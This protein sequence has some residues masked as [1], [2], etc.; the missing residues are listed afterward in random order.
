M[1]TYGEL[2]DAVA[3]W[4]HRGDLAP[5]LS[6]FVRFAE[7]KAQRR[8]RVRQMEVTLSPTPIVAGLVARPAD[9][10]AVKALWRTDQPNNPL[11]PRS[12]DFVVSRTP[13]DLAR[14]YAWDGANWRFDGTGSVT[15]VYYRSIPALTGAANWLLTLD[16]QLYLYGTLAEVYGWA[17]DTENQAKYE[18]LFVRAIDELNRA[19]TLDRYSGPLTIG[20]IDADTHRR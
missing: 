19:D 3:S 14:Y 4:S 7:I 12:L 6:Q 10:V 15:G 9:A 2:T 8:L 17:E 18:G 16:P 11:E 20:G 1:N 13:T 5:L